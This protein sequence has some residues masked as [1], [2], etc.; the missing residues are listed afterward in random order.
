MPNQPEPLVFPIQNIPLRF[1]EDKSL[2]EMEFNDAEK[3]LHATSLTKDLEKKHSPLNSINLASFDILSPIFELCSMMDWTSP[4]RIGGVSRY[5]RSIVLNTP[6]AWQ[7]VDTTRVSEFICEIYFQRSRHC[8]LHVISDKVMGDAADKV[9]CLTVTDRPVY[10][11]APNFPRLERLCYSGA[12]RQLADVTI[13]SVSH[14]PLLRHL[15]IHNMIDSTPA[16]LLEMPPLES[17]VISVHDEDGWLE[18]LQACQLSLK[19]LTITVY[20]CYAQLTIHIELPKLLYLKVIDRL[21]DRYSISLDLKTPILKTYIEANSTWRASPVRCITPEVVTNMRLDHRPFLLESKNLRFLQL[22]IDFY[23]FRNLFEDLKA[24]AH[25][26]PSLEKLEF[27]RPDALDT[28]LGDVMET[29]LIH[30]DWSGFPCLKQ[31]PKLTK[32]WSEKLS[33]ELG[34]L[35]RILLIF[36]ALC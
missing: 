25:R 12:M 24:G 31:P 18:I 26:Y 30:W 16:E 28:Y 8:G 15:E 7:F 23:Q 19:S 21:P 1:E 32:T 5:W 20:E 9:R 6:R 4:L 29:T 34:H 36:L 27:H 22:N 35:V 10:T 13:L 2:P 33:G 11:D 17:L 3:T 14:F